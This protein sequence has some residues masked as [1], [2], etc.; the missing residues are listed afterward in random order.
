MF[1]PFAERGIPMETV[2]FSRNP[3]LWAILSDEPR[4]IPRS[5]ILKMHEKEGFS[6]VEVEAMDREHDSVRFR[7]PTLLAV[8]GRIQRES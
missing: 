1:F 7:T 6:T 5:R 8:D 4:A 3:S 2:D